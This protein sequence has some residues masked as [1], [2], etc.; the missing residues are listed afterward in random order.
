MT[1]TTTRAYLEPVE[2]RLR[3]GTTVLLRALEPDD[4]AALRAFH[5]GLSPQT[6]YYRFFCA[7]GPLTDA[8]VEYFTHVDQRSR[9]ALAAFAGDELI[10]VARYDRIPGTTDA[11]TACVVTDAW[12]GRGVGTE[13]L[14]RLVEVARRSGV[15]RFVAE[16]LLSNAR[17]LRLLG[18]LAPMRTSDVECGM[19]HVALD[20]S[21]RDTN[22]RCVSG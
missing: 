11:E 20:L 5:Q 21:P 13:L 15:H 2:R 4:G 18:E 10:A 16:T 9:V 12:Q 19:A 17:M 22:L 7:R 6:V 3:D 14:V 1:T 8:E